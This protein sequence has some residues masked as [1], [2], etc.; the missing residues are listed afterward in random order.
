MEAENV[1]TDGDRYPFEACATC[2][3]RFEFDVSYP[4]VSRRGQDG[5]LELYS[6][7]DEECQADWTP[8][9]P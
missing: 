2:G 6:F 8:D 7:C 5:T 4:V 9:Q 1:A 3:S